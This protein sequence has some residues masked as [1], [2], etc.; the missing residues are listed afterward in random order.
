MRSKQLIIINFNLYFIQL[1]FIIIN[2]Y[3][4]I[5]VININFIIIILKFTMVIAI[6]V[7]ASSLPS[8]YLLST[9]KLYY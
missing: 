7:V 8:N 6:I 2:Y 3:S 9:T 4:F 1:N 5:K